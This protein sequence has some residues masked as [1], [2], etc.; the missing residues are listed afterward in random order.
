MRKIKASGNKRFI[1][2]SDGTPFFL[3]IDTVWRIASILKRDSVDTYLETRKKQGFTA[4]QFWL[5]DYVNSGPLYVNTKNAYGV[6]IFKNGDSSQINPA[7]FDHVDYIVDKAAS[8]D[9]YVGIALLFGDVRRLFSS[10]TVYDFCH[11][12]GTHY[13]DKSNIFWIMGGDRDMG[14]TWQKYWRIAA[15]AIIAGVAGKLRGVKLTQA[16]YDKVLMTF[17]SLAYP[18]AGS[19]S[20]WFH[21]DAWL[22]FNG[23]QSGHYKDNP[24]YK[25]ITADYRLNPPKP[26]VDL[27]PWYDGMPE[28]CKNTK[29]RGDSYNIRRGAYWAVFAG[30]AGHGYGAQGCWNFDHQWYTGFSRYHWTKAINF[31]SAWQLQYVRKLVESRPYLSRIPDQDIILSGDGSPVSTHVQATHDGTPDSNNATYI[32]IYIPD[33]NH[34]VTINTLP[35]PGDTLKVWKYNPRDG[36]TKLIDTRTNSGIYTWTTPS[37]GPDW[38]LV[39]DDGSKSYPTPGSAQLRF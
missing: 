26:V 21:N 37:D 11:W 3:Q 1:I 9:M 20:R 10:T 4:I 33:S 13:K 16:D 12:L 31:E 8:L 27:E 29:I 22:G 23:F 2:Q 7:F 25:Y 38:V 24:I 15:K 17:H 28:G 19:S 35:L 14:S 30:A 6:P 39:I 5:M 34:K 18:Y 32:M 36:T